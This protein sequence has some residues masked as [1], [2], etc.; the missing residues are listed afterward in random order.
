VLQGG[1]GDDL[2]S[3]GGGN[4][5]LDG[6]AGSDTVTYEAATG[7]VLV[8]LLNGMGSVLDG[9]GYD[10]LSNIE[11]VVGSQYA[12]SL[13]GNA[14]D[15][16]FRGGKGD[17][18][19]YGSGGNDTYVLAAGDGNDTITN[20]GHVPQGGGTLRILDELPEDIWLRKVTTAAGATSLQVQILGEQTGA[21]FNGWYVGNTSFLKLSTIEVTSSAGSYQL[22]QSQVDQLVQAMATYSA[23]HPGFDPG[24]SG[25][26]TDSAVLS[27]I[28]ATWVTSP[29]H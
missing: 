7:K 3:G 24:T 6:G 22:A 15:N 29:A 4:N 13:I 23:A 25:A 8:N 5:T 1:D 20:T 14:S 28:H 2:L 18:T 9:S 16:V 11:N 10:V 17:D 27:A 12:D 26:I 19:I 21:T